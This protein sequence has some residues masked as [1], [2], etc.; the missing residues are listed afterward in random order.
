MKSVGSRSLLTAAI[1]VSLLLAGCAPTATSSSSQG[2]SGSGGNG[3][4]GGNGGADC[5]AYKNSVEPT[6]VLFSSSAIADGPTEGQVYGDGSTLSVTL[7]QEAIDLG[8]LPQAQVL[9]INEDG[10][11]LWV[12]SIAFVPNAD[13]TTYSTDLPEIGNDKLVGKAV[14]LNVI[15]ISEAKIEGA[16][17]N[18]DSLILGNYCLTYANDGS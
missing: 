17:Q 5:S 3:G 2:G 1:V 15:D 4:N 10:A 9:N 12:S 11:P 6:L 13:G 18:G 8:V 14:V 7:S 16:R